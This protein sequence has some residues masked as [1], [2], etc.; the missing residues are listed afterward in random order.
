MSQRC[1]FSVFLVV[2]CSELLVGGCSGGQKPI[3]TLY[4]GS[5]ESL[6][7]ENALFEFIVEEGYGYPVRHLELTEYELQGAF[8]NGEVDA[9]LEMWRQVMPDWYEKHLMEGRIINLGM[10]FEHGPQ[11]W[12]IPKWLAEEQRIE[13]VFDM[14]AH[15]ALFRNPENPLKGVFHNGSMAWES[16]KMNQVKLEAYGLDEYFDVLVPSA[17]AVLDA[18][19][20]RAQREHKPIFAYYWAP[21][22][23]MGMFQWHILKEPEY[24]DACWSN[25]AAAMSGREPPAPHRSLRLSG[26]AR[27]EGRP[28]R[29]AEKGPRGLGDAGEDDPR[30]GAD[31]SN[32][33]LGKGEGDRRLGPGSLVLPAHL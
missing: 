19:L 33:G 2:C 21:T 15:W 26:L 17:P 11:Y 10:M 8:E 29:P 13:T 1:A 9:A 27:R 25:I 28:Q 22:A 16:T 30:P 31:K 23:I 32:A 14:K 3:I 12:I 5:W 18:A 20:I 7:I 6:W 24:N 4:D